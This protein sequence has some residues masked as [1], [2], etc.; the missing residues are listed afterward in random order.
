MSRNVKR[1]GSHFCKAALSRPLYADASV[2][3]FIANG[4]FAWAHR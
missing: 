4:F 2:D 3:A 1:R